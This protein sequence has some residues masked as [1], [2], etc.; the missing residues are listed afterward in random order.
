MKYADMTDRQK[1]RALNAV[2]HEFGMRVSVEPR[3]TNGEYSGAQQCRIHVEEHVK[4]PN[5][6]R[7]NT[8][9][10]SEWLFM[11]SFGEAVFYGGKETGDWHA[12]NMARHII[13]MREK[14]AL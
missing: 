12:D 7:V 2:R 8:T 14:G 5:G 4:L 10:D 9:T 3:R 11:G 6:K 1:R 13:E